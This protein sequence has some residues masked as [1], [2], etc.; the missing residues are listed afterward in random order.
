MSVWQ[1][2][3]ILNQNYKEYISGYIISI[4]AK[5]Q[6]CV[7]IEDTADTVPERQILYQNYKDVLKIHNFHFHPAPI[8]CPCCR[9]SRSCTRTTKSMSGYIL[10]MFTQHQYCVRVT[11]AADPVPELQR[12]CQAT[13]CPCSPST[14]TVCVL[15]MQQILYQNYKED[16]GSFKR[17]LKSKEVERAVTLHPVKDPIYQYHIFNYFRSVNIMKN[18]QRQVGN[19][20]TLCIH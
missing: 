4:F 15:Q 20:S 8:L 16:K 14:N 18:R 11:D 10:S 9:C 2:Q 13:Y 19:G 12:V 6:Y 1:I 7:R 5:H 3:Q 17:T